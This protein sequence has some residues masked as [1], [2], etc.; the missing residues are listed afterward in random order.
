MKYKFNCDG[1]SQSTGAQNGIH[2]YR[3]STLYS[4]DSVYT[5]VS[6]YK[7]RIITIR[8]LRYCTV[9]KYK[10]VSANCQF[11]PWSRFLL[12]SVKVARVHKIF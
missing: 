8:K 2:R 12:V 10:Y 1:Q 6:A 9:N 11:S 3:R 5:V 4:K 7:P